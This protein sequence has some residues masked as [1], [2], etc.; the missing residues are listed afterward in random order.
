M[1]LNLD[2]LGRNVLF[3]VE[4]FST[5]GFYFLTIRGDILLRVHG[6]FRSALSTAPSLGWKEEGIERKEKEKLTGRVYT[7]SR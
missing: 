4:G 3:R 1:R 5:R 7:F 6:H 2:I